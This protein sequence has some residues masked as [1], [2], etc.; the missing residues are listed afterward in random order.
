[1][2]W[3]LRVGV[4]GCGHVGLVTAA[5]LALTGHAVVG[6]DVDEAR[7]AGLRRGRLPFFEPVLPAVFEGVRQR[8]AF[9]TSYP[10]LAGCDACIVAVPSPAGGGGAVDLR[11][12]KQACAG[13]AGAL[14]RRSRPAPLLVVNKSTLPAG[15]ARLVG[16]LIAGRLAAGAVRRGNAGV[17]EAR[18]FTVCSCP[19]FLREGRA[20]QDTLFPDRLVFGIDH[21]EDGASL[22]ALYAPI[23]E[24]T[25]PRL[26]VGVDP[27]PPL[28][29]VLC[30]SVVSAE[31]IKYAANA[32]LATKISFINEMA[33]LAE[34]V[35]ADVFEVADGIGAD[36]RIGR[37]FLD[38]G[39]GWGG[40]CFGKDL[41]ALLATASE[42][43]VDMPLAQA[44][45]AV[46]HSQR[47]HVVGLLQ[48]ELGTLRGARVGLLGLAFKPGT[49]DLRDAP[50]LEIAAGLTALGARVAA[51]DPVVREVDGAQIAIEPSV[52]AVAE[53]SD[54]LV[55][56]TEWEAFRRID[57]SLIARRMRRRVVID[58]RN[59]LDPA[60]LRAAGFRYRGLGR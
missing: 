36:R 6:V 48:E 34:R 12:L 49:D 37:A 21:P 2:G 7:V 24:R 8:L 27:E 54:A 22:R 46:N 28:P 3:P 11:H 39:V 33:R 52:E 17:R 42:Y 55:L 31:L 26:A 5:C 9:T 35:G 47:R 53:A 59:A 56:V 45:V 60:P 4:V 19:E 40:S 44:V 51:C 1:M 58:G 18:A 50:S 14:D 57:W 32:F 41:R 20:V 38:A 16:E 30:T 15:S 23:I 29:E 13:I 25:F 10:E 43:G